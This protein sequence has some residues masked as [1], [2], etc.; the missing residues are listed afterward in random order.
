MSI[1]TMDKMIMDIYQNGNYYTDVALAAKQAIV[2]HSTFKKYHTIF[3]DKINN[4]TVHYNQDTI[5]K[6]INTLPHQFNMLTPSE[7]QFWLIYNNSRF[8]LG[9]FTAFKLA[10]EYR[11]TDRVYFY[12]VQIP[13]GFY[14]DITT[15]SKLYTGKELIKLYYAVR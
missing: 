2:A 9:L 1:N 4:K 11:A 6:I 12:L 13:S 8:F 10:L 15:R 5:L 14:P 3:V 7:Q